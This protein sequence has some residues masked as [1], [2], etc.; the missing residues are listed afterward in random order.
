MSNN[1]LCEVFG[2]PIT[3]TGKKATHF[4]KSRLC[5]YYNISAN[6]TKDKAR[7]PLG[8]CSIFDGED[9]TITCP[10]RFRQ[11][12]L[13]AAD[14]AEYFFDHGTLWTTLPEIRLNDAHGKSAGNI[15]LVLVSYDKKGALLDF[16]AVEIR[17]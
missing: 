9:T 17:N 4:R 13:I 16:G 8:V 10:V 3:N 6:C 12:W 15:D 2:F 14:T 1:P 5:P 7:N 11:D